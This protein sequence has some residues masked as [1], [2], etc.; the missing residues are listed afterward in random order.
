MLQPNRVLGMMLCSV[1]GPVEV[2]DSILHK[3]L[4][5]FATLNDEFVDMYVVD[6]GTSCRTPSRPRSS[7][8]EGRRWL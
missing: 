8:S 6:S 4:Q 3:I 5:A 7:T 1:P 2:R